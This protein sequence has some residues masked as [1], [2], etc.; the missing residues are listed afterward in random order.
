[1]SKIGINQKKSVEINGILNYE[2][3][4]IEINNETLSLESLLK[5]FDGYD[6][7]IILTREG[8]EENPDSEYVEK[9]LSD[10]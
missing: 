10:F 5:D 3:K 2:E 9:D 1:M 4:S 8:F 6:I 7:K